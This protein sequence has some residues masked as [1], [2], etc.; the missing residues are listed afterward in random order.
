MEF[1]FK[2]TAPKKITKTTRDYTWVLPSEIHP[3]L[4]KLIRHQETGFN[5]Y[6]K[7]KDS[8]AH[9]W[10]QKVLIKAGVPVQ[11]DVG[12]NNSLRTVR[13]LRA[14]QWVMQKKEYEV[15]GWDPAPPNPLQHSK[16]KTTL[17]RYAV[18]GCDNIYEA[19]VRCK[20]KYKDD[21]ELC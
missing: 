12:K 8:L 5:S 17:E 18:K 11:Y 15:M 6:L 10:D 20:E 16:I 14:T 9:Y 21:P 4:K 2:A 7:L 13:A 3:F 19:R 1:K